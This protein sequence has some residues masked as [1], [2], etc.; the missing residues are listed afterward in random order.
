MFPKT[1]SMEFVISLSNLTSCE[2]G[3]ANPPIE[4]AISLAIAAI[5]EKNYIYIYNLLI[6]YVSWNGV[7][8]DFV[9]G[10]KINMNAK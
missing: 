7:P 2:A 8:L 10:N 5:F 9:I 3:I 6:I 4:F 1:Y